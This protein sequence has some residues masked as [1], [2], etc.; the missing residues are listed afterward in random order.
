MAWLE[1]HKLSGGWVVVSR[2]GG[3]RVKNYLGNVAKKE[4]EAEKAIATAR[5]KEA[6]AGRPVIAPSNAPPKAMVYRDFVTLYLEWREDAMPGSYP[7]VKIHLESE[8]TLDSFGSLKIADDVSTLDAWNTAFNEWESKRG[9]MVS[10]ETLK[11]EWKDIK[12]SLYRAVRS[13]GKKKGRRWNLANTSPAAGLVLGLAETE[14]K[15]E[16]RVFSPDE[17]ERIYTADPENA[18]VWKFIANT[19]LRRSEVAVL[20]K[21]MVESDAD[22]AKVRVSHNPG[23]GLNVKSGKSRSV[24]LNR[25]ARAAR[26][27]I[28]ATPYPGD[29]FFPEWH[30]RTWTKKFIK[31]RGAAGIDSGTLHSLRHT[32]I[33]R[34]ANNGVPIHLVMKWAG[35]SELE[36]TM[37]YLH[38][39]EDYEWLEMDKMLDSES[40]KIIK[41]DNMRKAA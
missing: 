40:G 11:G 35:H 33:S 32:F 2:L 36:T 14:G 41:L 28:L 4:A 24:P 13:G 8:S 10:G 5:E 21:Y 9:K 17:L 7:T 29:K 23:E 26:D 22:R 31:A 38:I 37:G 34:A 39:N 15:K 3:K 16:K 18:A 25:E 19:G 1:K 6:K 30:V 27:E 20:P 12:A